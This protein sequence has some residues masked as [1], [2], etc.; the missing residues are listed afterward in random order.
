[1]D[2]LFLD[3]NVLFAAAYKADSGLRRLWELPDTELWSSDYAVWEALANLSAERP[4][5]V[6][7][8]KRLAGLLRLHTGPLEQTGLPEEQRL[9]AKDRPILQAA[10]HVKA[11][12]LITNDRTHFGPFLGCRVGGVLILRPSEYLRSRQSLT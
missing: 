10:F 6:P 2:Q 8:L 9:P 4:D 11:T 12:H 7:E 3:A 1:M 5:Q